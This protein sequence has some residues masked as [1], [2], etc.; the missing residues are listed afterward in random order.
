MAD[1]KSLH[2]LTPCTRIHSK[3]RILLEWTGI[4]SILASVLCLA[5]WCVSLFTDVADWNIAIGPRGSLQVTE[6]NGMV[7]FS[8]NELDADD[9]IG[10]RAKMLTNLRWRIPGFGFLYLR[11][12]VGTSMWA[13]KVSLLIPAVVVT[14]LSIYC[15]R[16]YRTPSHVHLTPIMSSGKIRLLKTPTNLT[17]G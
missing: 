10:R 6:K 2:R 12:T 8:N 9:N 7:N 16:R 11:P 15:F 17:N 14:W 4:F 1:M 3:K 13:V 5:N